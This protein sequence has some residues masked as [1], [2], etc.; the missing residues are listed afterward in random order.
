MSTDSESSPTDA[1]PS[2]E[3]DPTWFITSAAASLVAWGVLLAVLCFDVMW[4]RDLFADFG[5]PLPASV[6][7]II[8]LANVAAEFW[9][10][11]APLVALLAAGVAWLI[12]EFCRSPVMRMLLT[13]GWVILPLGLATWC[14]LA[15]TS[16]TAQL[17]QDVN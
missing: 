8:S 9:F 6:I 7:A 1:S 11:A 10:V 13:V 4:H 3:A 16:V 5:L 15:L 14:H 12:V 2:R 17:I